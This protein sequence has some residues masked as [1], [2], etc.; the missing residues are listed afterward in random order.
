MIIDNVSVNRLE[1]RFYLDEVESQ[2]YKYHPLVEFEL[3]EYQVGEY[4]T[5]L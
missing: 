2:A 3:N 4:N 5:D 1:E